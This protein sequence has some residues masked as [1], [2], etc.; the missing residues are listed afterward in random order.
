MMKGY[1]LIYS[2]TK[3][4]DFVPDFL[5]RPKDLDCRTALRYVK[6]AMDKLDFV[7]G[8]RYTAFSVGNYCVC[9][10]IACIS[11]R[12]VDKLKVSYLDF[13]SK[14][15]DAA[16]YLKDEKGRNIA[17]FIGI[18]IPKPL[19]SD[20]RKDMIPDIPLEQ[21]WGIYF[22]YLKHQWS[23]ASTYSEQI[24]MPSVDIKEKKYV[25]FSPKIEKYGTH[26]IVK[27]Y[28]MHEQDIL[29]YFFHSILAG[30]DDSLIT[31][32]YDRAEW[33]KLSFKTAAVSDALYQAIKANP[34]TKNDLLS[35]RN[36]K[37][38]RKNQVEIRKTFFPETDSGK[39]EKKTAEKHQQGGVILIVAAVVLLII[40]L[41]ILRKR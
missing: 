25:A 21:Y 37:Q 4:V 6:D 12:L 13:L 7:Q 26:S 41:L 15:P 16:E 28:L 24:D 10:G 40:L 23:E 20:T 29:D 22:E 27:D 5:A 39:E 3:N 34:V 17:C 36:G 31:E 1:P 19:K 33:E 14:Y 11:A 8:I 32:I 35:G 30:S 2:R 18:A 9:G 38:E